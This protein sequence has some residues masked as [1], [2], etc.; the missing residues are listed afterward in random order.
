[1]LCSGVHI[2]PKEGFLENRIVKNQLDLKINKINLNLSQ[3]K[4]YHKII[5]DLNKNF[6]ETDAIRNNPEDYIHEYFAELTRQVDLQRETLIEGINEYSDELIQKIEKLKQECVA[7]S[8]EATNITQDLVTIKAKMIELNSMFTK[9]S[10]NISD[11]QKSQI[12]PF[13]STK[14]FCF[15]SSSHRD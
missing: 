3:F 11:D 4:D 1:M 6:K 15:V 2:V 9:M 7:K 8:K 10:I 5:Q 14:H 13:C 12:A